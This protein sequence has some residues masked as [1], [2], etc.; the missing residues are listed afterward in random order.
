MWTKPFDL[1]VSRVIAGSLKD[2]QAFVN[3]AFS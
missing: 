2:Y 1:I 3:K